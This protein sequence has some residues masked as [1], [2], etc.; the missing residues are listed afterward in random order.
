MGDKMRA[1]SLSVFWSKCSALAPLLLAIFLAGLQ[2]TNGNAVEPVSPNDVSILF[3]LPKGDLTGS[4]AIVDLKD[5]SGKRLIS[6]EL[7]E[8]FINV[9]ESD[10]SQILDPAGQPTQIVFPPAT[11]DLKAWLIAGIR[12]DLGAPGLSPDVQAKFG[13]IPQIRLIVQP[14]T[15]D[16]N[17]K[18]EVHDRA[19]HFIFS[20][21]EG[22]SGGQENCNIPIAKR[23]E[24]DLVHFKTIFK[25]FVE[26]RDD[27]A[28]G[29]LGSPIDTK[30]LLKVH[31]G[32]SGPDQKLVRDRLRT[33]LEE[34]LNANQLTALAVMGLPRAAP[35]PWIFMAM[36]RDPGSG[37][38]QAVPSPALDGSAKAQLL[39][40]LGAG[41]VIPLPR[42]DNQSAI[43][44]CFRMPDT[45]AGVST[46]ELLN[47]TPT[48]QR[49]AEVT[50]IVADPAKSHF[51]NTDCVSCHTET[52]LL[53][54]QKPGTAI[55]GVD[56]SVL[57][58]SRWNVRNF[59]WGA[60]GGSFR[61]TITRRTA[62]ETAEVVNEANR[63]LGR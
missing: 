58:S 52:R 6:D 11:K 32:L 43:T 35:E 46:A 23:V 41:H 27:L 40:F 12:L 56:V 24:P 49:A 14:V 61:A 4:I 25:D 8:Q 15:R 37:K 50:G 18:I 38:I 39:G 30:G 42:A 33:I 7:F 47:S 10:D 9:A 28:A 21:V 26:F 13:Q 29:K 20:F 60:E 53:L 36:R 45:R 3:P 1:N 54:K 31:P 63:L 55:L 48:V 51:F 57:P 17:G 16:A 62:A 22:I 2:P 59:G 44:T 5:S 34:N 19:A